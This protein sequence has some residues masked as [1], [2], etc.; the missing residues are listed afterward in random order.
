[1]KSM[2]F[3]ISEAVC[4]KQGILTLTTGESLGQV[5]SQTMESMNTINEVTNYPVLRP[6]IAMHKQDII[7]ISK[8]ID[9]Y[10]TSIHPYDDCCTVFVPKSPATKP[11]RKQANHVASALDDARVMEEAEYGIEE[12]HVTDQKKRDEIRELL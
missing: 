4:R 11:K 10:P 8:Q 1:M 9:T 12:S 6:L 7:Q 3:R 5:A 2:M